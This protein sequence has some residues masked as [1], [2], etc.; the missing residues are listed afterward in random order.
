MKVTIEEEEYTE[1][2]ADRKR[3]KKE[4]RELR[5]EL[6]D[7]KSELQAQSFWAAE[8]D[9]LNA[10]LEARCKHKDDRVCVMGETVRQARKKMH[11]LGPYARF[12]GGLQSADP[13]AKWGAD[14]WAAV[15]TQVKELLLRPGFLEQPREP[16]SVP[17]PEGMMFVPPRREA[18][19]A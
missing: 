18:A 17:F 15:A 14:Q 19:D 11:L 10:N 7:T 1:L 16:R 3:Y 2:L 8:L 9:C 5:K 6:A 12:M 13:C 4:C